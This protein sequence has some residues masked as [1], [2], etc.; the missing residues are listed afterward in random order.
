MASTREWRC[1]AAI[2]RNQTLTSAELFRVDVLNGLPRTPLGKTAWQANGD[3]IA[4]S[5]E[6]DAFLRAH[7]FDRLGR[8][9]NHGA[10]S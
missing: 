2:R 9:D 7:G 10:C 8:P 3:A 5:R 1:G 4:R 6:A